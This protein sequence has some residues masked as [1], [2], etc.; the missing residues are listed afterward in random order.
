MS[1]EISFAIEFSGDDDV[2]YTPSKESKKRK[3]FNR[4][5]EQFVK[6]RMEKNVDNIIFT[7]NFYIEVKKIS[8]NKKDKI[9]GKCVACNK[10]ICGFMGVSSNFISYL[11]VRHPEIY[12]EYLTKK[13][14]KQNLSIQSNFDKKLIEFLVDSGLPLSLVERQSFIN[15]IEGIGLKLMSRQTAIKKLEEHHKRL[16]ESVKVELATA[17]HVST[18]A[19][20]WSG[21]HR[22]FFGYT[23]HWLDKDFKRKSAALACKRM[24]GVH[25]AEKSMTDITTYYGLDRKTIVLSVTDKG[26]NF[27][28]AFKEYGIDNTPETEDDDGHDM[29]EF[30]NKIWLPKHHRCSS[31]TLSLLV[32]SDLIKILKAD[33]SLFNR[34]NMVFKKCDNLR[35]MVKKFRSD[36]GNFRWMPRCAGCDVVELAIR[37]RCSTSP[38]QAETG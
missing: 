3:V 9:V 20:I 4:D 22:S 34:N 15:L 37:C 36:T 23:C 38:A 21:N 25:S 8:E 16:E 29:S 5:D 31:H 1:E 2:T 10:V 30:Q 13:S 28:K 26:S 12:K 19:D 11:R 32:T 33:E 24:F 14:N 17:K 6:R 7:S 27:V 18:T 35:Q